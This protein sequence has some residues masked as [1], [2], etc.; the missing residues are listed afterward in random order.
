LRS[1]IFGHQS[2]WRGRLLAYVFRSPRSCSSPRVFSIK[3]DQPARQAI[4]GESIGKKSGSKKTSARKPNP[5]AIRMW[6]KLR[7]HIGVSTK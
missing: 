2:F 1:V 3:D 5:L 6:G 4:L 7:A